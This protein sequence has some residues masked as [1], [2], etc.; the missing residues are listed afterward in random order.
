MSRKRITK[1][2]VDALK[3]GEVVWDDG[4][5]G[6]GCRCQKAT[7][8]FILKTR[9][10]GR[11]R[12][13]TIGRYGSPWTVDTARAEAKR[14]LG[15]VAAKKDPAAAR[16]AGKRNPTVNDVADMFLAEHVK[17]KR[18]ASTFTAYRDYFVRLILPEL[19]RLRVT[20]VTHS[21]VARFHHGLCATPYQGNR[22]VAILSAMFTWAERRGYRDDGT[23]PCRHIDKF[24]EYQ[25]ERFL[26]EAEL[27]RLG[28]VLAEVAHEGSETPWVVAALRL[29]IFTGAR[30]NEILELEWQHVDFGRAMLFLRDSKTGPKPI[31]LNAPALQVLADVPR[32]EGN[33]FVICGE[34]P[35]TRLVN[36]RK[37]WLRI[38]GRAGL[39]GV[40][41]HDL[42][43]SFG[44][45]AASGGVSLQM[46]GRLLGHTKTVTTE[47][48][49]HLS[50]D[51]VRA[52]NEAIGQRI[53]AA[54]RGEREGGA[55]VV[56][57]PTRRA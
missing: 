50:A 35:G 3:P 40:R 45:M 43:H 27:A 46:T 56:D 38:R 41:L 20:D 53:A 52:A 39:D 47:R 33:P 26:S 1:R 7:K 22:A 29:L 57:L 34:K 19:G 42:R 9:V 4:V 44:A 13:L 21:D 11:Q 30:R 15:E 2:I 12:W 10:G 14:L 31:Y 48:Y 37:P 55:E 28:D 17:T 16:D 24:K 5:A 23:N 49:S 51:P 6:F 54:M 36:L 8:V 18:K 32:M 25:R